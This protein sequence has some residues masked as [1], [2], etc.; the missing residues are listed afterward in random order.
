MLKNDIY[1]IKEME[2]SITSK[3]HLQCNQ[4]GF[5][6]P[7]QP[8]PSEDI[9]TIKELYKGL[10]Y[11][12]KL[13]IKIQN[14]VILGGEPSSNSIK[15][16]EA[17]KSFSKFKNINSIEVVTHGL[18]PQNFKKD[19]FKYIDKLAISVYYDNEELTLLW[20]K[21]ISKYYPKTILN[22]R[23]DQQW[24][25]WNGDLLVS[26]EEAQKLYDKCWYKKHCITLER[27]RLFICAR[28]AKMSNDNEGL[29]V[30]KNTTLL[31]VKNYLESSMFFNSCKNCIPMMKIEK[32]NSGEQPDDRISKLLPF[33]INFI[34]NKLNEQ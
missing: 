22:F 6:I 7:N 26:D 5:N 19:V 24:D 29:Y 28:I 32:V 33:A 10:E 1:N 34:K 27:N 21:Y 30:D 13:N 17:V 31:E 2:V 3:C 15:L 18:T 12:E 25:K 11:L 16:L 23:I 4:C 14:L 9:N 20:K 8:Y